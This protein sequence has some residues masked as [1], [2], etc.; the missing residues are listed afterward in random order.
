[1]NILLWIL[2]VALAFLCV[3]GGA[4]KMTHFTQLQDT[5]AAMK[6]LP[7]GLWMFFGVFEVLGGL[8]LVLPGLLKARAQVL[9][10]VATAVATESIV[11][12]AI[13]LCYNDLAPM[14][15]TLV[16]AGLALVIAYGRHAR[17]AA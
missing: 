7:Q 4:Y 15:F 16:G 14:N 8:G 10:V 3:S 12:S 11:V 6:Q 1:M 2:Q 5:V 9:P 17:K 13:Y